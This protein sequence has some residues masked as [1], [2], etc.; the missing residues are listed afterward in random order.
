MVSTVVGQLSS[1]L[2][3]ILR[4]RDDQSCPFAMFNPHPTDLRTLAVGDTRAEIEKGAWHL[5]RGISPTL[6]ELALH[7]SVFMPFSNLSVRIHACIDAS[8]LY[9]CN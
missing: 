3:T 8:S 5:P 4:W 9:N 7:T 6:A 1:S 2:L